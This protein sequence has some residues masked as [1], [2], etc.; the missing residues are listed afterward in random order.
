MIFGR[1]PVMVLAFLRAVV[2]L[3]VA[4]GLNLTKEQIAI[5]YVVMEAGLSLWARQKVTPV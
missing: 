4:F 1:E 2:L 3:A 5:I